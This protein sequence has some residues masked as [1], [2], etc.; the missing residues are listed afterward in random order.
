MYRYIKFNSFNSKSTD[1]PEQRT[2]KKKINLLCFSTDMFVIYLIYP[3]DVK[4]NGIPRHLKK[5]NA[6][7]TT[8]YRNN[9]FHSIQIS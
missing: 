5:R 3:V 1:L 2:P 7:L 6:A 8:N 4:T 9:L